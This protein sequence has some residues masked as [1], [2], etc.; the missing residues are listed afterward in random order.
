MEAGW[1]CYK[2][3]RFLLLWEGIST[4]ITSEANE[5][6]QCWEGFH[7]TQKGHIQNEIR[8]NAPVVNLSLNKVEPAAVLHIPVHFGSY[9]RQEAAKPFQKFMGE[10]ICTADHSARRNRTQTPTP[11]LIKPHQQHRPQ[12]SSSN[13][14]R[15]EDLKGNSSLSL[16]Q[17]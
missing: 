16:H 15:S 1:I 5:Y 9:A 6:T 3:A 17:F 14:N 7:K 11:Q 13:M 4:Q 8:A 10:R 2:L 12:S